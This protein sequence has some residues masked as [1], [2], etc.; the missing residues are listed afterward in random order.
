MHLATNNYALSNLGP[1]V[2]RLSGTKRFAVVYVASAVAGTLASYAAT[3]VASVGASG[4]IFGLGGALAVFFWRHR[5]YFGK[6][7]DAVLAQLGQSLAVNVVMG[8]VVSNVD[9]WGHA[10]GLAGGAATALL[11]GPRMVRRDEGKVKKVC[12][13]PP[14]RWLAGPDVV[15]K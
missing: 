13:E 8:L 1:L 2:E 5:D 12:D 15:L 14:C 10:G 3:P 11:L 9:N 6:A 7:S 4:A